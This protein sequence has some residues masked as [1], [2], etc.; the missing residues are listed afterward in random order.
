MHWFYTTSTITFLDIVIRPEIPIPR[1]L[2]DVA[3]N[4]GLLSDIRAVRTTAVPLL[5]RI[6]LFIKSRSILNKTSRTIGIK[7]TTILEPSDEL[8]YFS[9]RP[10]TIEEW[11]NM[12]FI[13][14][15]N[16]GWYC[17]P[18][19]VSSYSSA[20][21]SDEFLFFD[22]DAI[23]T[24]QLFK[25]TFETR[26]F[27][28]K[29][30]N[31]ITL[32]GDKEVENLNQ[33]LMKLYK[34]LFGMF[35][36]EFLEIVKPFVI[37]MVESDLKNNQK[38]AAEFFSGLLNSTRYW[39]FKK[40]EKLWIWCI[41]LLQ[42]V[43]ISCS[44]ETLGYW[45]AFIRN[46]CRNRDSRRVEPLIQM[47]IEYSKLDLDSQSFFS[48]SKKIALLRCVL[49]NCG[50][51]FRKTSNVIFLRYLNQI[52]HPYQQ[53]RS[54]LGR[55]LNAC[56]QNIWSPGFKNVQEALLGNFQN[57]SGG[58]GIQVGLGDVPIQS[59]YSNELNTLLS[60]I[61]DW[62]IV[63]INTSVKGTPTDFSMACKT[64]NFY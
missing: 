57:K 53:V 40:L 20:P 60:R 1:D 16:I 8:D 18:S 11:N 7:T 45:E 63:A 6:C 34:S 46:V 33:E 23:E 61:E 64:G 62:K 30:F 19:K 42:K 27:W 43:F 36:D 48:E 26:I 32:E 59:N 56:V 2:I 37:N 52:Q 22:P 58:V 25:T 29:F 3:L 41:P 31:F 51:R 12:T 39:G 49:S 54:V 17:Y 13:D 15:Q 21:D 4:R 28:E 5:K 55:S 9:Q 10:F 35:Q 50:W 44:P 47:V 14:N 24:I 38:A